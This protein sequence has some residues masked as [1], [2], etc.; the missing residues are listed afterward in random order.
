ME[1]KD[2]MPDFF[3]EDVKDAS[4]VENE[5]FEQA[6]ERLNFDISEEKNTDVGDMQD[7]M[8]VPYDFR[9]DQKDTDTDEEESSDGHF[10]SLRVHA[11]GIGI[12]IGVLLA[13][14]LSV[15]LFGSS[16]ND[17]NVAPIVIEG[18]TRATKVRPANPAGME[19]PDQDKTVYTKLHSDQVATQVEVIPIAPE[20]PVQPQVKTKE[21]AILG[22]PQPSASAEEMEWEV[23]NLKDKVIQVDDTEPEVAP[24]SDMR[25]IVPVPPKTQQTQPRAEPKQEVISLPV[26]NVPAEPVQKQEVVKK[27]TPASAPKK[28]PAAQTSKFKNTWHVQLISL[29]SKS[30]TN[31]EWPKIL[32]AHSALLSGLPQ[33]VKEVKVKGTTFY[34]LMVGDFK[35]KKD[36]QNLCSKLKARKQ[37]CTITK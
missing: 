17:A 26:E 12:L 34:R 4:V 37:D 15:F 10:V 13:I 2:D 25:P 22:T 20:A 32:K 35:N 9:A 31:K 14:L 29:K 11:I 36:A 30:A 16:D 18:S 6:K 33:E 8:A 27:P 3:K 21:G 23:V 28:Q 5:S 1:E 7:D 19:I 24:D